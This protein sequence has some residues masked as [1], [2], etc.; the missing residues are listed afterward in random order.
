[1]GE[2]CNEPQYSSL[3]KDLEE[4]GY[5]VAPINPDW[6]KPITKQLMKIESDSIIFGF[7]MG[8]VLAYLIVK[9]YPCKKAIFASISPVHTFIHNDFKKFLSEHMSLEEA[10]LVTNDILAIDVDL[11]N[12]KT[13]HVTLM[14]DQ[15]EMVKGEKT[16][17]I[18]VPGAA[19][20]IGDD[21]RK[22]ILRQA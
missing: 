22:A 12:L 6:K 16:P 9:E 19:H 4:M 17:D 2:S 15:E 11:Q 7:S 3:T 13:P 20:E 1:M 21:Y 8:A 5:S 14:G 10:E 18:F